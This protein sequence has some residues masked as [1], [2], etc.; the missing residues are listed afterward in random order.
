MHS[1]AKSALNVT[2]MLLAIGSYVGATLIGLLAVWM[3]LT[4]HAVTPEPIHV[5][6]IDLILASPNGP[7]YVTFYGNLAC[8]R[9]AGAMLLPVLTIHIL[10]MSIAA[11]RRRLQ[12]FA[13]AAVLFPM[14][15]GLAFYFAATSDAAKTAVP[16][17]ERQFFLVVL[18]CVFPLLRA[19][20]K[21]LSLALAEA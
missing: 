18:L 6:G 11:T 2:G 19:G 21:A 13:A 4:R 3:L 8:L 10:P 12:H 20:I 7:P 16:F 14:A 17:E 1:F 9:A 5:G 15:F